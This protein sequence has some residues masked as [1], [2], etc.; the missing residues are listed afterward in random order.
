MPRYLI[1]RSLSALCV[2]LGICTV[3]FFLLH[4]V[5]GDPVEVMLGEAALPADRAALR[6]ALGLDQPIFVQWWSYLINIMSLDLGTSIHSQRQI[7][8]L[9]AERLPATILMASAGFATAMLIAFPLGIFA[10]LRK[11]TAVDHAAMVFAMFGVSVPNFWLGPLLILVFSYWLGLFPVSGMNGVASV[12]LPALTLG[13]GL[14]ALQA[15]MI[16][17][18]LLE[19][20]HEDYIRAARAR[21][22][23]ESR[24]IIRHAVRN[25][26]LPVVTVLGMQLGALLTGSVITEY[27]F[28]WP[29]VGQLLI[30]AI[31]KRDYPVVQA[32]ILVI[33]ATYVVV[34]LLTD[35]LYSV[36]D[37][38]VVLER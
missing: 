2:V 21:G 4:L 5:P 8:A 33:S 36:I 9:L 29:G 25:A 28:D 37:P 38:R 32:C 3:V 10:A 31:H 20:L 22:I 23:K 16:R 15:R 11:N 14:A 7:S 30:D 27:V 12:V 34:N 26:L 1:V 13:T 17:T 24:I 35:V 6:Q 19:V 18:A